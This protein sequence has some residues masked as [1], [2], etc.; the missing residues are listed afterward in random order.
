M[1]DVDS[2]GNCKNC[3]KNFNIYVTS[4]SG[5]K[6]FGA[7]TIALCT[8]SSDHGTECGSTAAYSFLSPI[9]EK[10]DSIA[11]DT[12]KELYNNNDIVTV[13]G[14]LTLESGN[15]GNVNIDI[16]VLGSNDISL[17]KRTET[18]DPSGLFDYKFRAINSFAK[19]AGWKVIAKYQSLSDTKIIQVVGKPTEVET[20]GNLSITNVERQTSVKEGENVVFKWKLSGLTSFSNKAHTNL[21]CFKPT[22]VSVKP[23]PNLEN[24][25]WILNADRFPNHAVNSP[26][27]STKSDIY[28]GTIK[29]ESVSRYICKIHASSDGKD[30]VLSNLYIVK[31]EQ[32]NATNGGQEEPTIDVKVGGN[33]VFTWKLPKITSFSN[34]AHT[35]LHCF[36]PSITTVK[37]VNQL[38]GGEWVLNLDSFP[39]HGVNSPAITTISTGY[40]GSIKAESVGEY[41]CRVH[42]SSDN[43]VHFISK[44]FKI[45]VS[46]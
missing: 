28:E 8:S 13:S 31:V 25:D 9:N 43:K 7:R 42:A 32:A 22:I 10:R 3:E 21:H 16:E 38:V 30:H 33:I 26:A 24:E 4:Y 11:V 20:P 35:N 45:E 34:N 15:V 14:K 12:D 5:D 39:E 40:E 18:T 27:I 2:T 41:N 1:D 23:L 46:A 19:T 36:K 17:G 6:N 44:L 29:S 37:P